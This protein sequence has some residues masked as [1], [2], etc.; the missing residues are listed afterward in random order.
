MPDEPK[1][2]YHRLSPALRAGTPLNHKSGGV[3]KVYEDIPGRGRGFVGHIDHSQDLF[4]IGNEGGKLIYWPKTLITWGVS[5]WERVRAECMV[6]EAID[7][8][9]NVCYRITVEAADALGEYYTNAHGA[10]HGVALNHWEKIQGHTPAPAPLI[11]P[12]APK[13]APSQPLQG[14]LGI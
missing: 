5:T 7:H 12:Q 11:T 2:L 8:T 10:R 1:T 3:E 4:Q 13:A 6:I 9:R 14:G